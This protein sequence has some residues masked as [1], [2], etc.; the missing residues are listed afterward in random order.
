MGTER[1]VLS[2]APLAAAT[3]A[4]DALVDLFV[5][6]LAAKAG[7][8][9]FKR[10]GQPALVGEILAGVLIGPSLLG[11]AEPTETLEVFAELGVVFL[12]FWVGLE[13]R[14]SDMREV[15][16][17][18]S[19]VGVFGVVVPFAAGFGAGAA[20]GESAETSVFVGAALVAT[21]V[22]ITSAV[23]IELGAIATTA[24]RTVL[25]AAVIDDV[26]AM[27]LLAVAVGVAE[28]GGVDVGSI[29]VVIGLAVAFVAFV[30]LGGTRLVARWPDL[31]HA[32]RFSESPLLPAV[33]LC[34][35]LAAFAAQIGLAAIIGAFLAGMVCAEMRDRR[36]FEEEVA[37]LYAFF[38]PFFFVFIGLEVDLGAFGDV[39]VLLALLGITALAAATKF[40]PA[41]LAA[42]GLGPRDALVVG[43]GMVPRGEVGIIVAGIGATAG[44]VEDDLFAVIVGMSILTTLLVPPVLRR[45]LAAAPRPARRY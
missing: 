11:L 16:R 2:V 20:A 21:S 42:R 4:A 25:G 39:E 7:D 14:L 1:G 41:W 38:P 3:G 45:A 44:V 30:A 19:G 12:L 27:V 22:G 40:L 36:D 13:T 10:L 33:I 29:A 9:L 31:F 28:S 35:G 5:V 17:V 32:P 26:L 15:G 8:E 6:L 18:A 37:P 34:L 23:L 43:V 24:A